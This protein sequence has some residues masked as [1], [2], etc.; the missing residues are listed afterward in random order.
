MK[1][2]YVLLIL[3]LIVFVF[4]V[5]ATTYVKAY[6]PITLEDYEPAQI[7][8]CYGFDAF[9]DIAIISTT[10]SNLLQVTAYCYSGYYTFT[11]DEWSSDVYEGQGYTENYSMGDHTEYHYGSSKISVYNRY[12]L[13]V[14]VPPDAIL[15]CASQADINISYP[16]GGYIEGVVTGRFNPPPGFSPLGS[17]YFTAT[18]DI[19]F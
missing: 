19:N 7:H 18:A 8:R 17:T 3:F 13:S 9:G 15:L 6:S 12:P 10:T 16:S 14:M 1:K 11:H 2:F 5:S 4:S